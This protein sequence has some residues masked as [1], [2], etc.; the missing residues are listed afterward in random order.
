MS[1]VTTINQNPSYNRNTLDYD[2]SVL[3]LTSILNYTTAIQ[4]T[5]LPVFGQAIPV[6]ATAVVTG[7]GTTSEN[8]TYLSISLQAVQ[9]LTISQASCRAVYGTLTVTDRMLCASYVGR[10]F[11]SV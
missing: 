4:P 6:N 9:L 1:A 5:A 10:D 8:G 11:C 2:I 3:F 7:W